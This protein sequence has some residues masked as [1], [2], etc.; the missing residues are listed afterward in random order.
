MKTKQFA[1]LLFAL[2]FTICATA[3]EIPRM[4]VVAIDDSKALVLASTDKNVAAEIFIV[5]DLGET[6][7]YK[8]SKASAEFKSVLNLSELNDGVYTVKLKTGDELANCNVVINEGHV[9]VEKK[10]PVVA[11]CFSYDGDMVKVSYFNGAKTNVSV[12]VYN[13]KQLVLD[14]RLGNQL[15]IQKA[16]DVSKMVPGEFD[17]IL[18]AD[19]KNYTYKITR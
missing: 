8:R 4:N 2:A 12:L 13:G 19:D 7:Y 14:S 10:K 9:R 15:C 6:I 17:F 1:V 16:F 3:T 18:C 11:P 5:S